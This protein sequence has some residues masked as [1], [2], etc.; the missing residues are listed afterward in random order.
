MGTLFGVFPVP[1]IWLFIVVG[2]SWFIL[3]KTTFGYKTYAT[4]GNLQAAK[5][6]GINTDRVKIINFIFT[7][8]AAGLA[9]LV[10]LCFLGMVA[11]IQGEGYELEAIAASVIGG[12][13]LT[14]GVGSVVGSFLGAAILAVIR[15]GLVLMGT[16]PYLQKGVLGAVILIAVVVNIQ[17]GRARRRRPRN[18]R[19]GKRLGGLPKRESATT[20]QPTQLNRNNQDNDDGSQKR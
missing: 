3:S 15:N 17:L 19:Y 20:G 18:R 14:G 12:T 1:I 11:P 13:A 9:G 16:N 4:G 6:S 2:I 7:S 10:S 5:L 8:F